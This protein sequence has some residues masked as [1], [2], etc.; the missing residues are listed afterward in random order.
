MDIWIFR[1]SN[2][3]PLEKKLDPPLGPI[4]PRRRSV[5]PY[6]IYVNK[7]LKKEIPLT[8]FSGSA[9][10]YIGKFELPPEK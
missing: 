6:V 3:D 10:V 9:H 8:K 4:A 2:T 7:E 5:H 1:N